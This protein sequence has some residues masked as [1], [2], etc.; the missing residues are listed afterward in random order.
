LF[1]LAIEPIID[2]LN[3]KGLTVAVYMDDFAIG[4]NTE[5]CSSK[6][7]I[8]MMEMEISKYGLELNKEKCRTTE[9]G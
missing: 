9:N 3:Q 2:T 1:C 5:V 6:D 7:V 8:T 4:H